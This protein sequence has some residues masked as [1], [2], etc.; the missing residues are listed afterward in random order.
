MLIKQATPSS[1]DTLP[2]LTARRMKYGQ[3]FSHISL[4]QFNEDVNY[5]GPIYIRVKPTGFLLNSEVIGDVLR[6][7]DIL[8]LNLEK[9]TLY[10]MKGDTP[11]VLREAHVVV[12]D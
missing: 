7:G 4:G 10:Y 11:V 3:P 12:E 8:T 6:R 5:W 9:N 1:K 2:P